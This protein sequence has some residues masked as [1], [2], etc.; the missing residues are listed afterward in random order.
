MRGKYQR[1]KG[2]E[3]TQLTPILTDFTIPAPP[4]PTLYAR[5]A[6][7]TLPKP[8]KKLWEITPS[9]LFQNLCY[10]SIIK[11]D[12]DFPADCNFR[13]KS[14]KNSGVLPF[15][16][17]V[18]GRYRGINTGINT[19][20][21]VST[22]KL[23][24]KMSSISL[25]P[26]WAFLSSKK[27]D[28]DNHVLGSGQGLKTNRIP[29]LPWAHRELWLLEQ[30]HHSLASVPCLGSSGRESRWAYPGISS[31]DQRKRRDTV[32]PLS[33]GK[34][35]DTHGS[36]PSELLLWVEHLWRSLTLGDSQDLLWVPVHSEHHYG[37]EFSQQGR[38]MENK[39][40]GSNESWDSDQGCASGV[41][42]TT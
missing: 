2:D 8:F 12:T 24:L 33:S 16:R 28:W 27:Q 5:P 31:Q 13:K 38:A 3:K 17:A 41:F 9:L 22:Q 7:G 4:P 6:P 26:S 20:K 23:K 36:L 29:W 19:K 25:V 18:S 14:W 42:L 32:Q 40:F 1:S 37:H 39:G 10:E 34:A 11:P 21:L 30:I 35:G 15:F